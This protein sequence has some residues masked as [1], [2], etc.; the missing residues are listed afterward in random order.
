MIYIWYGTEA[1]AVGWELPARVER[2]Y[3]ENTKQV[4]DDQGLPHFIVKSSSRHVAMGTLIM[5]AGLL[6]NLAGPAGNVSLRKYLLD[7]YRNNTKLLIFDK[8]QNYYYQGY[9]VKP[10]AAVTSNR[11]LYSKQALINNVL[12]IVADGSWTTWA[13]LSGLTE[14]PRT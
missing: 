7:A 9:L 12:V 6:D 2:E 11:V 1:S 3:S 4:T 8:D 5:P 14:Y 13:S 10:D